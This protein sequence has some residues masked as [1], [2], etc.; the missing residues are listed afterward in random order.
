MITQQA[1][2]WTSEQALNDFD[3]SR[4]STALAS[5]LDRH[6]QAPPPAEVANLHC[7]TFFSFNA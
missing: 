3:R 2:D 7:H 1:A 4:R 5:L 6:P